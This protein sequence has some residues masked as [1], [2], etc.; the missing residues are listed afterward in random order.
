MADA[1]FYSTVFETGLGGLEL[2]HLMHAEVLGILMSGTLSTAVFA[3]L[4]VGNARREQ[5]E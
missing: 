5:R 4:T 1:G 3:L 2:P